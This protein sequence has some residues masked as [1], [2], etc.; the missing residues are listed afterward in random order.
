MLLCKKLYEILSVQ[1]RYHVLF[2][3]VF[4]LI[5]MLLEA[6][7]IGVVIPVIAFMT[8][9]NLGNEYPMLKPILAALGNPTQKELI[10][11]SMLVLI[12]LYFVK[13]IFL[14]FLS[15]MQNKFV[16]RT[17]ADLSTRLF[18][19]Y[20]RQPWTFHLQRNSA[21]LIRNINT[22]VSL[23]T[24]T[25]QS[26]MVV[27]TDGLVL[28]GIVGL[29][30]TIAALETFIVVGVLGLIVALF[31][32]ILKNS[33]LNWGKDRQH[34]DGLRIQSL[35]EGFGGAKDVKLMG[36]EDDFSSQYNVHNIRVAN[37]TAN[38]RTLTDS[39]RLVLEFIGITG[40]GLLVIAMI[41]HGVALNALL[42]SLGLFAA[43]AFKMLP[44]VNR[45]TGSLQNAQYLIPA[46]NKIYEEIQ[47]VENAPVQRQSDS[48]AFNSSITLEKI[49]YKYQNETN[50]TLQAIK[51]EIKRGSSVGFIG[52][53]GAGKSTLIDVILGLLP[54]DAGYVKVDGVDIQSN[55]RGWQDKIG[56]VPQSIFLTD[57]SIRRN[58]AF[59]IA[60]S[61]IDNRAV[62]YA[63]KAAH[64]EEL[65][66]NL[67]DGV[68]TLV[69]ER[70]VRLS[71]G[72]RQ[73]IGIA[74]ALY[75]NPSVLVLDEA[76][77]SLDLETEKEV[78]CAVNAMHGDKTLIIVAHRL[79][80]LRN[81]D[82]LYKLD[83]G[84]LVQEGRYACMV[85]EA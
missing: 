4:M 25:M 64:L 49:D 3:F 82:V 58:I 54:P 72:Q 40:L 79:S 38:L 71:G 28:L 30:V 81:C 10:I 52:P 43:A 85:N 47:L 73:R 44:S 32:R 14:G 11:G 39:T 77:S 41:V 45:I 1:Q 33:L 23:F 56:Y 59:G 9:A 78:M 20:L 24:G 65:I 15:W 48:L 8:K 66:D 12:S 67:P 6:V 13:A 17:S 63:F 60:E 75:H 27:A 69:G 62:E 36:R 2:L 76:T 83:R 22:E 46:V 7:G 18:I 19:G 31:H 21:L 61:S 50:K 51:I 37:I 35:Q 74:R 80:T 70:G 26:C 16:L 55:L 29:L 57:D 68:N 84:R 34:H 53:S 5:A 42:P